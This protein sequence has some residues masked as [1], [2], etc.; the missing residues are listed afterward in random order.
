MRAEHHLLFK[1]VFNE[2]PEQFE[3][4][5]GAAAESPAYRAEQCR[6][7]LSDLTEDE[8]G[9]VF[10]FI[11]KDPRFRKAEAGDASVCRRLLNLESPKTIEDDNP[12]FD[13]EEGDTSDT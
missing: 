11:K 4:G 12:T 8:Q 7:M 6:M 10:E 13:V 2:L 3:D 5:D 9:A 1:S